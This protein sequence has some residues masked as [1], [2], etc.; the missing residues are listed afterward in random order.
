MTM[1][2]PCV[3]GAGPMAL[4]PEVAAALATPTLHPLNPAFHRLYMETTERLRAV[5]RTKSDVLVAPCSG[6]GINEAVVANMFS[7]GEKIIVCNGGHYGG[8]FRDTCVAYG[9][10]VVNLKFAPGTPT[11]P[12]AVGEALRDHPDAT[13]V[14]I[15]HIETSTGTISPLEEIARVVKGCGREILLIADAVA[16]M[17][18]ALL[19]TDAWGVDIVTTASQKALM[20]APG[21]GIVSINEL[22][23]NRARAS[24]LPKYYFDLTYNR[25]E[26]AAG[27]HAVTP[28]FNLIAGLHRALGLLLEEGMDGVYARLAACR[29]HLLLRLPEI[30]FRPMAQAGCES[31]TLTAAFAPEGVSCLDMVRRLMIEQNVTICTAFHSALD[32]GIRIG[33]MG[34]TDIGDVHRVLDALTTFLDR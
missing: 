26:V 34:Y 15:I 30:G 32:R 18:G 3:M 22:G 12:E 5:F 29:D 23:W 20:A 27:R 21:L 6:T 14:V 10:D 31:P 8:R 25:S 1:N 16:S 13:A 2:K 17:G 28:A 4:H 24:R 11:T 33:H 19:D 7:A 9:V